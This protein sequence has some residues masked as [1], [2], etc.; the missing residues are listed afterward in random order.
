MKLHFQDGNPRTLP[1]LS[2][3]NDYIDAPTCWIE[4]SERISEHQEL[5]KKSVS[6]ALS[7]ALPSVYNQTT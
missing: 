6:T 5:K 2:F 3:A 7:T 1:I 4:L